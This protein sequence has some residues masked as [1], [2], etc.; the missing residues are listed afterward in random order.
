M[1]DDK[2]VAAMIG[3]KGRNK[4]SKFDLYP[5]PENVTVALMEFLLSEPRPIINKLT[6]IWEPAAGNGDMVRVLERYAPTE[7]SD[8]QTGTDY[9]TAP[10]RPVSA[11]I[12]NPPFSLAYEFIEHSIKTGYPVI[13]MLLKSQFWHVKTNQALMELRRPSYVLPLTWRPDFMQQKSPM[14]DMQW[15]VWAYFD[16]ETKY[17][18]LLKPL[19]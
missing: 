7:Y 15:T 2:Y 17:I 14:L 10:A 11:V 8:I 19:E 3:G 6:R 16:E 5:T 4:R 1:A 9:L 18:P 13:A 12:T